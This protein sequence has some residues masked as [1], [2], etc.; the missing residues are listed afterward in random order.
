MDSKESFDTLP[1]FSNFHNSDKPVILYTK[2]D[3][4]L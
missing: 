2:Y 3:S 4:A 1:I